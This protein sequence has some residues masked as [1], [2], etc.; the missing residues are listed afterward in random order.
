M[1]FY[2]QC[3]NA[4]CKEYQEP[5]LELNN[6]E[7]PEEWD[8]ICSECGKPIEGITRF[9]KISMRG[10]GQVLKSKTKQEA[11]SVK[12]AKCTKEGKPTLVGKE[13]VC[14]S[15]GEKHTNLSAPFKHALMSTL[16]SNNS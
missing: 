2:V 3:D 9:A 11:F 8:A 14:F 4:G 1:G 12:C 13:L 6:S 5:G 7:K 10:M 16:Q 15:C